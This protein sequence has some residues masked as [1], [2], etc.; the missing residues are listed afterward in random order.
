[1]KTVA[2]ILKIAGVAA[3]LALPAGFAAADADHESYRGKSA[4]DVR[5]HQDSRDHRVHGDDY[6]DRH[7]ERDDDRYGGRDDD[8]YRE[9]HADRDGKIIGKHRDD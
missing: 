4:H 5:H 2:N 7:D 6:E 1:M 8:R 3:V 9:A